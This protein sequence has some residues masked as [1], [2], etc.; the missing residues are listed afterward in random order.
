MVTLTKSIELIMVNSLSQVFVRILV[1][2]KAIKLQ[3][4]HN[5]HLG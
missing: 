3:M 4:H 5:L 2:I 1:I